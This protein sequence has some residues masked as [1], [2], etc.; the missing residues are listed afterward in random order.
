LATY[1]WAAAPAGIR[2]LRL[3]IIVALVPFMIYLVPRV[4]NL[5]HLTTG[6]DLP[7]IRLFNSTTLNDVKRYGYR[8]NPQLA[9]IE[10]SEEITLAALNS[11]DGVA[12][13]LDKV[14]GSVASV[15]NELNILIGQVSGNLQNVLNLAIGQV[16]ALLP[17]I[18][19]LNNN[20]RAI[21]ASVNQAGAYVASARSAITELINTGASAAAGVH[22]A[23]QS[24]DAAANIVAP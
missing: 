7:I 5:I 20:V 10:S 9:S 13:N 24:A 21:D 1:G 14:R 2:L 18:D 6:W 19:E 15:N 22:S 16:N 23:R 12:A 3:L 8:Y 4:F 11:L 17:P